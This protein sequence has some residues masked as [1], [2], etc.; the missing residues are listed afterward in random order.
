MTPYVQTNNL[1]RT[2]NT[3]FT[4]T[5]EIVTYWESMIDVLKAKH[6][7]GTKEITPVMAEKYQFDMYGL[8]LE[9][10]IPQSHIYPHIRVNG[11]ASSNDYYGEKL[12]IL[13]LDP[14]ILEQ[15]ISLFLQK[16]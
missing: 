15:Y 14:Y 7:N 8:F 1:S 12:R 11:Y 13:I 16:K 4:L 9:L 5:S 2:I 10:G 6:T 3:G